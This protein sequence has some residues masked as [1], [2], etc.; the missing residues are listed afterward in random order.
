MGGF[1]FGLFFVFF[2]LSFQDW[3]Y[4]GKATPLTEVC[5]TKLHLS[6]KAGHTKKLSPKSKLV[7]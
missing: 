2:T 5:N 3:A 1:V 4:N 7:H 6:N